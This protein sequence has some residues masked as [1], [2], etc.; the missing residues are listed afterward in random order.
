[1]PGAVQSRKRALNFTKLELWTVVR[2]HVGAGESNLCP[3][4]EW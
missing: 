3:L 2:S 4:E 1:M